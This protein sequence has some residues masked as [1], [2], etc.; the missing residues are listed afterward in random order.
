MSWWWRDQEGLD[1]EG[2]K[3]RAAAESEGEEP[4]YEEKGMTQD[5][6]TGRE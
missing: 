3:D 5:D 6:V 1:L 4:Q 2:A